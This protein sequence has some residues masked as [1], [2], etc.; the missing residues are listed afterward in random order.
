MKVCKPNCSYGSGRVGSHFLVSGGR[1]GLSPRTGG[2]GRVGSVKSD[3]CST[4]DSPVGRVKLR[5]SDHIKSVL[6]KYNIPDSDLE[7]VAVLHICIW[8]GSRDAWHRMC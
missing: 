4:L 5:Y 1:V 3:P 6:S 8:G 7:S 2:L